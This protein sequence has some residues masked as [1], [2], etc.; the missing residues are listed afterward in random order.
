MKCIMYGGAPP[1]IAGARLPLADYTFHATRRIELQNR[2]LIPKG[3]EI[4]SRRWYE[5]SREKLS[6]KPLLSLPSLTTTKNLEVEC[7]FISTVSAWRTL[8]LLSSSLPVFSRQRTPIGE[9]LR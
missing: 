2:S 3:T 1:T 6:E 8:N 4:L 7:D 5:Y 9:G